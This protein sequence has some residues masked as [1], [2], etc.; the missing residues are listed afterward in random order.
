M[1]SSRASPSRQAVRA[2]VPS[3][4]TAASLIGRLGGV[5]Q[6]ANNASKRLLAQTRRPARSVTASASSL[7]AASAW[8]TDQSTGASPAISAWKSLRAPQSP[9]AAS[10]PAATKPTATAR[11]FKVSRITAPARNPARIAAAKGSQRRDVEMGLWAGN[12]AM[13]HRCSVAGRGSSES[14]S[15]RTGEREKSDHQIW[16]R[17]S[18]VRNSLVAGSGL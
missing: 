2:A 8:A 17:L 3:A 5:G 7:A 9:P 11:S 18:G 16:T 6:P 12:V 1:P 14:P 13:R 10:S 15:P 4:A